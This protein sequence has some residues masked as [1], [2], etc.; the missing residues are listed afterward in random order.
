VFIDVKEFIIKNN[1]QPAP[2]QEQTVAAPIVLVATT[3]AQKATV[4]P[5]NDEHDPDFEDIELSNMRKVIAKRLILSKV[6]FV[7]ITIYLNTIQ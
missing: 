1:L 7:I 3:A 5:V 4:I 6:S 2:R